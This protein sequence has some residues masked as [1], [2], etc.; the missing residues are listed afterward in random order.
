MVRPI[1]AAVDGTSEG[2]SAVQ[3]AAQEA[4]SQ[5][6]SLR[7][8]CV[9]RWQTAGEVPSAEKMEFSRRAKRI[10]R[11]ISGLVKSRFPHLDLKCEVLDPGSLG[12]LVLQA[13]SAHMLV[14]GTVNRDAVGI[15]PLQ[16][17]LQKSLHN[18]ACPVTIVREASGG[19]GSPEPDSGEIVVEQS[20]VDDSQ[21]VMD[22]AVQLA[23]SRRASLRIIRMPE[24]P[25]AWN[26]ETTPLHMPDIV[27]GGRATRDG[28]RGSGFAP[29]YERSPL[30]EGAATRCEATWATTGGLPIAFD[31][32][33]LVVMG[34]RFAQRYGH[35]VLQQTSCPITVVPRPWHACE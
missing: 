26:V 8:L 29:L 20:G 14:V 1:T 21:H 27:A 32:A 31:R 13:G 35:A 12:N 18:V 11:G 4:F 30:P 34:S 17:L 22:F 24:L 5:R 15:F 23:S 16:S 3:W 2:L 19:G 9:W 7:V 28:T 33:R 25:T 10:A 6:R